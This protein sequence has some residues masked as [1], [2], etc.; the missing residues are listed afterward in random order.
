MEPLVRVAPG[1]ILEQFSNPVSRDPQTAH[2]DW[3]SPRT[4]LGNIGLGDSYH[5]QLDD[6]QNRRTIRRLKSPQSVS[7]SQATRHDRSNTD[8]LW[9][10]S[11]TQKYLIPHSKLTAFSNIQQRLRPNSAALTHHTEEC[12]RVT[13]YLHPER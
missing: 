9:L 2:G 10:I 13:A 11:C 6:S 5:I 1:F 7:E 8:E 4:G 3:E 12:R